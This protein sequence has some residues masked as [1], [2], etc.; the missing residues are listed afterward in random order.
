MSV[1]L[2]AAQGFVNVIQTNKIKISVQRG[3]PTAFLHN[4]IPDVPLDAF[5]PPRET[6]SV[7]LLHIFPAYPRITEAKYSLFIPQQLSAKFP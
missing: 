6:A 7:I 4:V 5:V 3:N 1:R 2:C